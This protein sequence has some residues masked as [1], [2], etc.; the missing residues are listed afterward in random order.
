MVWYC[1]QKFNLR[2]ITQKYLEKGHTQNEGDTIHSKI[3]KTSKNL[4]IYTTS[5][6]AAIIRTAPPSNPYKAHELNHCDFFN[7]KESARQIKKL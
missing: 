5:Q 4:S 7:F 3:E 6:W 1:L 2:S